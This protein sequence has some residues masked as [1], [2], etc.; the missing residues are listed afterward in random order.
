MCHKYRATNAVNILSYLSS[1][2]NRNVQYIHFAGEI[3]V[4]LVIYIHMYMSVQVPIFYSFI[5][6]QMNW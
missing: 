1:E 6:N 5:I 3:Y 2:L 4:N